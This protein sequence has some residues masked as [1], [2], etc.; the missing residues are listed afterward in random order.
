VEV[1]IICGDC[2]EILPTLAAGSVDA[3]ITDPP[4]GV[5]YETW[6]AAIPPQA[7][8]DDC[9]RVASGPV[10]MFGAAS[11]IFDFAQYDPQPDRVLIWA[12][13]FTL[14]HTMKDSI[15]YR[16][17]P[18]YIWRPEKP[19]GKA[20]SWDV[21]KDN[22]ECGN[23]W[24]HRATKPLSLMMKLVAGWGGRSVIDPFMGSG[25]TG[26]ACAKTGRNFIGIDIDPHYCKITRQRIAEAQA[27]PL[28]FQEAASS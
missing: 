6:D 28:L 26:V 1:K 18:I 23:W 14:S 4:Y 8:L 21:F 11:N 3:V 7:F 13:A 20:F 10:V 25:T 24:K 17:H 22:T 12:P 2:L 16:Y 27:Q 19:E 5:D 9:L 15:A